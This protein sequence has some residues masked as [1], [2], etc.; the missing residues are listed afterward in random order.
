MEK[1]SSATSMAE[2]TFGTIRYGITERSEF[3]W[4]N[5]LSSLIC[6]S[7]NA[8]GVKRTFRVLLEKDAMT[9]ATHTYLQRRFKGAHATISAFDL[10]DIKSFPT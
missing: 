6:L 1:L 5:D 2:R 3:L 8:R 4:F 9:L 10:L 7:N